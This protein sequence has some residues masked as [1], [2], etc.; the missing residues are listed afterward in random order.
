MPLRFVEPALGSRIL[1]PVERAA[2]PRQVRI[3]PHP[4]GPARAAIEIH[5][6][7][8]F[9]TQQDVVRIQVGMAQPVVVEAADAA[10]DG[11]PCLQAHV[12]LFKAGGQRAGIGQVLGDDVRAIGEAFTLVARRHRQWHRHPCCVQLQVQRDL[13]HRARAQLRSPQEPV[14]IH[15]RHESAAPVVTQHEAATGVFE[16]RG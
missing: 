7:H 12:V 14:R 6:Q 15:A 1:Q 4:G 9:A 16:Q 13:A 5:Q 10:A 11:G 3:T 8:H 2:Q